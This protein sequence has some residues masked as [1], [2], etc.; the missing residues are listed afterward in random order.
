MFN[1]HSDFASLPPVVNLTNL[2]QHTDSSEL[3]DGME[4]RRYDISIGRIF[5]LT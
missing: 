4:Q 2:N 5:G 3:L 1:N